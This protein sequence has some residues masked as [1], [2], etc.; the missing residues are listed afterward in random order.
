[1]ACIWLKS[2]STSGFELIKVSPRPRITRN[3]TLNRHVILKTRFERAF[4]GPE[5]VLGHQMAALKVRSNVEEDGGKNTH[6]TSWAF[7]RPPI[8]RKER[9]KKVERG[10]LCAASVF[11]IAA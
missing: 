2:P 7:H 8:A 1:M 4:G 6:G 9:D 3:E 11:E 10:F 5:G